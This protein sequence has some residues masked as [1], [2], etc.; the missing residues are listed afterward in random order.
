MPD[1]A[2]RADPDASPLR[3]DDLSGLPPAYVVVAEYDPLRDEALAYAEKLKAAGVP[4]TVRVY[5]DQSHDFLIMV[6]FLEAA[7]ECIREAGK[8]VRE[9][10][11]GASVG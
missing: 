1:E 10:L 7:D 11:A 9:A 5:D 6:N 4:V 8:A 2:D 3:A